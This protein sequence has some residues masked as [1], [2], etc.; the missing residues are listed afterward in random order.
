MASETPLADL[1]PR[2]LRCFVTLAEELHFGAAADRLFVAQ[3]ALSR[4]IQRLESMLDRSLFTRTTRAVA[5]TPAGAALVEPAREVL[6][7]LDGLAEDLEGAHRR[8]R[9]GHVPGTDTTAVI[10]DRLVRLE[11]AIEVHEYALDDAEQLAALRE[12]RLDVA[13][14]A[15]PEPAPPDL[16]STLVRLDPLLVAVIGRRPGARSPVDVTRRAVAIGDGGEPQARLM[17]FVREYELEVGCELRRVPVPAGSGTEA[18]ALRRAGAAAFLTLASFGVRIEAVAPTAPALPV[19]A[20]YPWSAVQ[21]RESRSPAARAFLRAAREVGQA[22]RWL[23]TS[24]LPG[25]PFV[26]ETAA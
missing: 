8:L 1:S 14:C 19:Q 7:R 15:G 11:P 21:R 3:P 26:G 2:L 23:E 16:R 12:G 24:S 4:S 13:V 5:L 17:A 20:Y 10:L 18:Y 9:V 25:R 22:R 6:R